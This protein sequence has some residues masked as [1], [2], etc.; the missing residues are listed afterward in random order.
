MLPPV[1]EQE[2]TTIDGHTVPNSSGAERQHRRMQSYLYMQARMLLNVYLS[3][4]WCES[5]QCR[6][7]SQPQ[8]RPPQPCNSEPARERKQDLVQCPQPIGRTP[9]VHVTFTN[10]RRSNGACLLVAYL[11]TRLESNATVSRNTSFPGAVMTQALR[12][13]LI[14]FEA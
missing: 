9:M 13:L 14:L 1:G 12:T 3:F 10:L 5:E 8:P 2:D 11:L 6:T 4:T 7:S